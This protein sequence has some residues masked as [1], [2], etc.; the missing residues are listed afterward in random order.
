M[1]LFSCTTDRIYI[2]IYTYIPVLMDFL[3]N[4]FINQKKILILVIRHTCSFNT[5]CCA[6]LLFCIKAWTGSMRKISSRAVSYTLSL[7][8][9]A[10]NCLTSSWTFCFTGRCLQWREQL[11]K[12]E[13]YRTFHCNCGT[14]LLQG[15][16]TKFGE[17]WCNI[18]CLIYV[19]NYLPTKTSP[20]YINMPCKKA[21][22]QL[23]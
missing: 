23:P 11:T 17:I 10:I 15:K 9:R 16:L 13:Y 14:V 19:I 22:L 4:K 3:N 1:W 5:A 18:S 7:T 21:V 8:K 2:H 6:L 20:N 12:L